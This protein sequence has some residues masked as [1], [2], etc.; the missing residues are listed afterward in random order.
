MLHKFAALGVALV[1][2]AT[3]AL[4]DEA[5][6]KGSQDHPLVSRMP[7]THII[8]YHTSDYQ[9][10]MIATGPKAEGEDLP[11]VERFEGQ[12]TV[13]TYLADEKS[14]S[15]LAI[16]R[17]F[18]KAFAQAGF[19][20]TFT[21]KSDA[22]CGEKFVTQL[23]WYG[24][25]QRQGQNPRLD[26]PN[27]HGDRHT[28]YYWSGTG[29]AESGDYVISLLVAQ[30]SAM[31]FPAVVVLDISKPEA[32]D[33]DQITINTEAMTGDMEKDGHV[34]L[35][36]VF[37]DFDKATLTPDSEPAL[38]VI[39]DYLNANPERKFFVVGH[40]DIEGGLD[41]NRAL[42]RERADAVI[43]AL[44]KDYG[45]AAAQMMAVGIGPVAPVTSNETET[46]RA[47]NRR[48]ELVA[49]D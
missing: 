24:D 20:E 39:A 47:E 48:V 43:D 27:R 28:Y 36:G 6:I 8:G 22:E 15:A 3:P 2:L 46:G 41:Y 34:V 37:F 44:V 7:G 14:L 21:C 26:A 38:T 31:N 19:E 18:E 29:E 9:E 17:N 45:V 5:D 40:T 4:A 35:D 10:F 25:P 16:F 30:H 42:S 33:D 11:P 12:S 1:C 23:Y 32:L 49:Q 13:I